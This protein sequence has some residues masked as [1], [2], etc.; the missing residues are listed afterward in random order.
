MI[1]TST[2]KV[3][4]CKQFV[5]N[6]YMD[7]ESTDH[8]QKSEHAYESQVLD[9]VYSDVKFSSLVQISS[10]SFMQNGRK[11]EGEHNREGIVVQE[12]C[13]RY[14]AT[15]ASQLSIDNKDGAPET[16][17]SSCSEKLTICL[18]FMAQTGKHS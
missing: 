13:S 16:E 6:N 2:C 8:F 1:D 7:E 12:N 17:F 10:S 9:G 11:L 4:N 3:K 18:N 5:L 15:N 14:Q